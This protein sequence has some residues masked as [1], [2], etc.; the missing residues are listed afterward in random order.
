M[1]V[2]AT[3]FDQEYEVDRTKYLHVQ[4]ANKNVVAYLA[5]TNSLAL[6]NTA[7]LHCNLRLV[8]TVEEIIQNDDNI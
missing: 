2:N 7:N 4:L 8:N 6:K 5:K 1:P 3:F